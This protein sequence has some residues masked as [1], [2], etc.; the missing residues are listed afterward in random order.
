MAQGQRREK[1][2]LILMLRTANDWSL[3]E[4][5]GASTETTISASFVTDGYPTDGKIFWGLSSDAL[6]NSVDA[7]AN[8]EGHEATIAGLQPNTL[9]FVQARASDNFGV[10]KRSQVLSI[11]TKAL[12]DPLPV[13]SITGFDGSATQ[14]KATLVWNTN[15]YPTT[16]KVFWGTSPNSLNN[17]VVDHTAKKNHSVDVEGLSP[18]TIYYFQ[19][20]AF[21]DK[22]QEQATSVIA[23]RTQSIPLPVWSITG[24]T[25]TSTQTEVELHWLTSEYATKGK[26]FWG[27]TADNLGNSVGEDTFG[28]NHELRVAGLVPNTIYF[29]QV[30]AVDDRGQEKSSSVIAVRGGK[31]R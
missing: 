8:A 27:S 17:V 10:E 11:R 30:V 5:S 16:G 9:Y 20:Y 2:S 14:S 23:V 15:Q 19:V 12:P 18:D 6:T 21:D 31:H 25:G 3:A 24:F 7:G 28:K 13:W 4:F 29:F 26:V 22:G 1:V